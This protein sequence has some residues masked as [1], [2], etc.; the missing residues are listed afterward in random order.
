MYQIKCR[1][2]SKQR[3]TGFEFNS[4]HYITVNPAGFLM[5]K[6]S[7]IARELWEQCGK[8]QTQEY[9]MCIVAYC[10][11]GPW[12]VL[13]EKSKDRDGKRYQKEEEGG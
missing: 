5:Y 1:I 3:V 2:V 6:P 13:C 8:Y 9:P 10:L 11:N 7:E 12:G 4:H